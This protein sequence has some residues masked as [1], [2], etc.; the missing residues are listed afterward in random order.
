MRVAASA[1]ECRRD[2]FRQRFG[3]AALLDLGGIGFKGGGDHP[4]GDVGK[5]LAQDPVQLLELEPERFIDESGR[6]SCHDGRVSLS[7][8]AVGADLVTSEQ[9]DEEPIRPVVGNLEALPHRRFLRL[10]LVE[11]I[12]IRSL[13]AAAASRSPGVAAPACRASI[14][15]SFSNNWRP[16]MGVAADDGQPADSAPVR[17]MLF[18]VLRR[19]HGLPHV[20]GWGS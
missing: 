12:S 9:C 17:V 16:S 3:T 19:L 4:L 11:T 7:C 2:R 8:V 15:A 14:R 13:A 20:S 5:V 18:R 10:Q 1:F 6:D